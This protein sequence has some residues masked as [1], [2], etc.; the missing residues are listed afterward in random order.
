MARSVPGVCAPSLLSLREDPGVLEKEVAI[1]GIVSARALDVYP[2]DLCL[3]AFRAVL[4]RVMHVD[5]D[6]RTVT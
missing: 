6:L 3:A 2:G 4:C 5:V 1:R